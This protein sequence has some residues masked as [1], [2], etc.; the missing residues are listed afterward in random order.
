MQAIQTRCRPVVLE[1]QSDP[2][3]YEKACDP[4]AVLPQMRWEAFCILPLSKRAH[5][6][7][8]LSGRNTDFDKKM[9]V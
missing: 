6:Y 1:W 2:P 4:S 3:E 7:S 9:L 5:E 8:S